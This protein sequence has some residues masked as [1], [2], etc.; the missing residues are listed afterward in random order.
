MKL[1]P[2]HTDRGEG[3]LEGLGQLRLIPSSHFDLVFVSKIFLA[4][5]SHPRHGAK[6]VVIG[7]ELWV[8]VHVCVCR[9]ICTVWVCI[10]VCVFCVVCVCVCVCV[11]GCVSRCVGVC[12]QYGACVCVGVCG[13][14]WVCV[15]AVW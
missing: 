11:C 3:G 12:L 2:L 8:C 10:Y 1:L 9:F 5:S 6:E 7:C 4:A 15:G 13:C 14:V